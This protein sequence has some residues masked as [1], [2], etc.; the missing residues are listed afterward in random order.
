MLELKPKAKRRIVI[1]V[2]AFLALAVVGLQTP[3]AFAGKADVVAARATPLGGG[4]Y[5]FDVTVRHDDQG[6]GHYADRFEILSPAG[7]VLGT[8]VLLHPH[9]D[10]QPFTRALGSLRIPPA[11]HRV[12]I[13]A[14]DKRD[15]YGGRELILALPGR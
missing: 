14:H 8:R 6:W 3:P 13:R 11:M 2:G 7:A 9:D 4:R 12:R 15:G 5:R 1:G 10:E